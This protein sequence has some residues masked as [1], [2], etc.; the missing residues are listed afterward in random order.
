MKPLS[1]EEFIQKEVCPDKP[2][3]QVKTDFHFAC[4]VMDRYRSH[5]LDECDKDFNKLIGKV[6]I[7]VNACL[8]KD[9]AKIDSWLAEFSQINN[10]DAIGVNVNK[11]LDGK[12]I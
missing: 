6:N 9:Q 1:P 12:A 2:L 5:L 10:D 8:K 3:P 4:R 11:I 7:L